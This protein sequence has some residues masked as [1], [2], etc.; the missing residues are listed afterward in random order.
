MQG[1]ACFT[2]T[3]MF[4]S[5]HC[6]LTISRV[7]LTQP[8]PLVKALTQP[9]QETAPLTKIGDSAA[10]TAKGVAESCI[11]FHRVLQPVPESP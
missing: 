8:S 4:Y 3:E 5:K 2:L 11:R 1:H 10:K 9:S 7:V 6:V